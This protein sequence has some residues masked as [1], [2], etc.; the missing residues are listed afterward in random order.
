[1]WWLLS[2]LQ[3][4]F[5]I[6]VIQSMVV[7]EIKQT[8]IKTPTYP[9]VV[10]HGIASNA[11]NMQSFSNWLSSEYQV[12]VFNIEIG[13]GAATSIFM[14]MIEQ[15]T[16]ICQTISLIP[17]LQQGFDFIG[18][19]QGGLLARGYVERCNQPPVHNLIT[20]VAP[21]GGV[22]SECQLKR[23]SDNGTTSDNG[24][25]VMYSDFIQKHLS[26]AGYWRDPRQLAN[27]YKNC[28]YLPLLN[29]E[30]INEINTSLSLLQKNN[31]K[32]L[33]NF[34]LVW[35][36]SDKI[37]HPPESAKFSFFSPECDITPLDKM[38]FYLEDTLGLRTLNETHKL[39]T[40]QTTC[41]HEA[42]RDPSCYAQLK[43]ILKRYL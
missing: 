27:Y 5:I 14:P 18:M 37:L 32:S 7:P 38:S 42:H 33:S 11:E 2:I 34:V 29:N 26:F 15:L 21:H 8:I 19:S 3:Y 28:T 6:F 22:F 13:N 9:V 25:D 36:S 16:D 23:A 20:L 40:Y 12:Q 31:I 24:S 4:C 17:A 39:H 1:M 43:P 35:S 41:A 10:L 30:N